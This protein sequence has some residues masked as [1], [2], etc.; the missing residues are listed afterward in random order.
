M[1]AINHQ[2]T[3]LFFICSIAFP[4]SDH[5]SMRED[6]TTPHPLHAFTNLLKCHPIT[7]VWQHVHED[8]LWYS[9]FHSILSWALQWL[10]RSSNHTWIILYHVVSRL[11]YFC[12]VTHIEVLLMAVCGALAFVSGTSAFGAANC[13]SLYGHQG[14]SCH[15]L[16]AKW[17]LLSYK[18]G[19]LLSMAATGSD[20]EGWAV[21]FQWYMHFSW[22][23][24]PL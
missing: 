15:R 9:F 8:V 17:G 14:Y 22:K 6:Y 20:L 4:T 3:L 2:Q 23:W 1:I 16:C 7:H 5:I 11:L 12:H 18:P 13:V 10:V 24:N 21:R 19:N